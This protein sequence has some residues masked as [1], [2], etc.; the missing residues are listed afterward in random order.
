MLWQQPP[1]WS[2]VPSRGEAAQDLG[3]STLQASHISGENPSSQKWG[4]PALPQTRSHHIPRAGAETCRAAEPANSLPKG[5]VCGETPHSCLHRAAAGVHSPVPARPR[6]AGCLQE[7]FLL[8]DHTTLPWDSG[9]DGCW[10]TAGCWH[11][12]NPPRCTRGGFLSVGRGRR[13]NDPAMWHLSCVRGAE[14]RHTLALQPRRMLTRGE[15]FL[16]PKTQ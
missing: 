12:K 13:K 4:G 5:L 8:T 14:L 1:P 2:R 6:R 9:G 11:G 10:G 15:S 7:L 3:G 16:T